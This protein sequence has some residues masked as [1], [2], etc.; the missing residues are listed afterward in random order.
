MT[1]G[2]QESVEPAIYRFKV[3]GFECVAINDG[4]F[5]YSADQY[6]SEAPP[7]V[8]T[9]ELAKYGLDRDSIPSP[10]T[11]LLVDTGAH[12]VV[13]D[14]GGDRAALRHLPPTGATAPDIGHFH[15]SLAQAGVDPRNV[16]RLIVT[17]AH[18]DH[19]GGNTDAT[20]APIFPDATLTMWRDEWEFWTSKT[21]LAAQPP[22]FAEPVRKHLLPLAERVE[23]LDEAR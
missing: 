9:P 23:L 3:G 14:T 17:H 11:C 22:V 20:G 4:T 19:I 12:V 21:T 8:L 13:V 15:E 1:T 5:F 16:D 18:P 10:Y 6:F 2:I 7:D